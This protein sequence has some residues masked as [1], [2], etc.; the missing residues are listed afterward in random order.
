[1]KISISIISF[2]FMLINSALGQSF[3]RI[4]DYCFG[5]T[6]SDELVK[7][8]QI[9]DR[10][11]LAGFSNCP[12]AEWDKSEDNCDTS[13][14]IPGY[15]NSWTICCDNNFNKIWDKTYGGRNMMIF[16]DAIFSSNRILVSGWTR[17]D[18][19][20][21]N[22]TNGK[23]SINNQDF[24]IYAIDNS[25][26]KTNE[27]RL[28]SFLTEFECKVVETRDNGLLIAGTSGGNASG[29]RSQNSW[30]L[31]DY[32]V[33]KLDSSG[34]K[35]WDNALGGNNREQD[36]G[37]VLALDGNNYLIYGLTSSSSSGL[38][39]GNS[40]GGPDGWLI[41][42]D[43]TGSKVWD[44]RYG[45]NGFENIAKV[46]RSGNFYYL[47]GTTNSLPN[48]QGTTTHHGFGNS[49]IWLI[50]TDTNGNLLWETKY[51][52]SGNDLGVDII[53]NNYGGFFVLGDIT[54][55][56]NG[57][58]PSGNYGSGDFIIM[59]IDTAGKLLA[60]DI[61]GANHQ[62]DA[63]GLLAINDSTLL[64]YGNSIVGTSNVKTCTGHLSPPPANNAFNTDYWII[65]VGYSTT[66][67]SVNQLQNNLALTVRPNPAKNHIDIS[68]LPPATYSINTYS[69]DGRLVMSN[70]IA[71]DLSLPLSI[72]SL[73]SGMYLSNIMNEKI[74]TTIRWVKE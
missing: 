13:I 9:G 12:K 59:S 54:I 11:Y 29:D 3:Y 60:Y 69:L 19:I 65:K 31:T 27:I 22:Y 55:S 74:N 30:G 57:S 52:A 48:G 35:Q 24:I 58:F 56:G 28:G 46:L 37:G 66:T 38:V 5:T 20:C 61:F 16:S 67:T 47:L 36:I 64:L 4:D 73:Q 72:E 32:W 53:S 39:S 1:M 70:L 10:F 40:F 7:V 43:N 25:G 51:G 62:D 71:S 68:G 50:K 8:F 18:S 6:K 26:N 14:C 15:Y 2:L 41:K 49:D 44:K 42:I 21:T 45:G 17:N 34:N 23:G 33:I 63:K